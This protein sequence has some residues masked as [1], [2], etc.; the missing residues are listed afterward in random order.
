MYEDQR[1]L[2]QQPNRDLEVQLLA[3][4]SE[5]SWPVLSITKRN[6]A[7][8]NEVRAHVNIAFHMQ[9]VCVHRLVYSYLINVGFFLVG[10]L[11]FCAQS[12]SKFHPSMD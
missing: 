9:T 8:Q 11:D 6:A 5:K 10:W 2:F 3:C 12:V 7:L 1:Q 4:T